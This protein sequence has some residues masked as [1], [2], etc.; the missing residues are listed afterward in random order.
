M[1]KKLLLSICATLSLTPLSTKS[2]ALNT[3]ISNTRNNLKCITNVY[4][5]KS[6]QTIN[7]ID[8]DK[9]LSFSTVGSRILVKFSPRDPQKQPLALASLAT[10]LGYRSFNWVN[11]VEKDPYGMTDYQG[12]LLSLPYNDPPPGG[13]QYDAADNYPFYWDIE[14]CENCHSR[15]NYQHPQVKQKFALNFEDYPSDYR[16]KE[17]ETVEFITHLVGIKNYNLEQ[18]QFSWDVLSTFKWQLTND[19]AGRGQI[20]LIAVDIPTSELSPSV[21]ALIQND[22]GFIP[23]STTIANLDKDNSHNHQCQLQNHQ[24]QHLGS[25]L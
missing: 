16:L 17:G 10:S 22:G 9:H 7:I 6:N 18:N 2:L 19:A 5:T 13:Y 21:L 3:N 20:S 25:H 4:S 1:Y 15:H 23:Q 12:N 14:Q 8:F 24:N 11:Y